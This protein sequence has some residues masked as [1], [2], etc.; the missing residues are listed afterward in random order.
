M[1]ETS[2][3]PKTAR[4]K[5]VAVRDSA[6]VW[7]KE[8]KSSFHMTVAGA[9][10]AAGPEVPPITIVPGVRLFMKDI[11]DLTIE[12]AA[13]TGPPKGFSN[14]KILPQWLVFFG[15]NIAHLPKP[16]VLIVDN[17]ATHISEEAAQICVEYGIMLVGLP[18]T[19]TRLFQ[20]LDVALFKPFK[21]GY[22]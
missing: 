1:D 15:D 6:N 9:V 22:C 7:R 8:T 2:F 14:S 3:I 12:R 16:V 13:I 17:S 4:R 10:S 21:D 5:V 20:P 19:A 11:A 18:A